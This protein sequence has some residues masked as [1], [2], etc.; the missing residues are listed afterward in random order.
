MASSKRSI[1][2]KKNI[3]NA[4]GKV[5]GQP[6]VAIAIAKD[7][8]N[9]T[10]IFAIFAKARTHPP[11]KTYNLPIIALTLKNVKEGTSSTYDHTLYTATTVEV[12]D[13]K[14]K[15]QLFNAL[16]SG[17]KKTLEKLKELYCIF[18]EDLETSHALKNLDLD[19]ITEY[20]KAI[21]ALET[22]N[23]IKSKLEEALQ[24]L[25]RAKD[26]K[27]VLKL[28]KQLREVLCTENKGKNQ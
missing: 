12:I 14:L 4:L 10:K 5:Y 13:E 21:T 28:L 25:E 11:K 27:Q 9:K 19:T 6:P 16:K 3:S 1:P 2:L 8:N 17:R 7:Q 20:I 26:E 24:H 22:R 18:T 15:E 23:E